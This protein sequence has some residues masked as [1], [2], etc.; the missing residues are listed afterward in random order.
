MISS[1]LLN[2]ATKQAIEAYLRRPA[3]ALILLGEV[4]AG[5]LTIA[6][7]IAASVLDLTS[8]GVLTKHPYYL[9]V[10]A[11]D[12]ISI[13]AVRNLQ[14]F[15]RF[16]TPGKK[17]IRRVVVIENAHLLTKEAQNALLKSLE[18]PPT[19]TLFILSVADE[20]RLLPTVLSRAQTIRV[21]RPPLGEA[22]N[23]FS[24]TG[25]NQAHIE[26]NY[27]L[28]DGQAGLLNELLSKNEHPLTD[29]IDQAKELFKAD[30]FGRLR[31]IEQIIKDK[32]NLALLLSAMEKISRAVLIS[33]IS[34]GRIKESIEW[35]RRL[36]LVGSAQ[37]SLKASVQTKLLV[38][39]LLLHI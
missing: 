22:I 2:Q 36:K 7:A 3:H 32:D 4:G 25:V 10:T 15:L 39:N 19:D 27:M 13:D 17:A 37:E 31:K 38:T 16:K 29:R 30:L 11:S 35:H 20:N 23:Y 12:S 18:E 8:T 34:N 6:R 28:G 21:Q 9:E 1:L 24:K 26:K 33:S 14:E 5:K